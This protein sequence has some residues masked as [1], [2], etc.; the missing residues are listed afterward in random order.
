MKGV[1]NQ[2]SVMYPNYFEKMLQWA[3]RICAKS[4]SS[5]WLQSSFYIATLCW[6]F[7]NYFSTRNVSL[8]QSFAEA[9]C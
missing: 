2:S 6:R 5:A 3:H 7:L 9:H 1:M 8:N 4:K